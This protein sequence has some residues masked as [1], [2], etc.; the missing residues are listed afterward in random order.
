MSTDCNLV[1]R[2]S[3]WTSRYGWHG[4]IYFPARDLGRTGLCEGNLCMRPID[5][6]L[7]W[8]ETF[9]GSGWDVKVVLWVRLFLQ[10]GWQVCNSSNLA[11]C[12]GKHFCGN[13][14]CSLT[15]VQYFT[16]GLKGPEHLAGGEQVESSCDHN[17][18]YTSWIILN[19]TRCSLNSLWKAL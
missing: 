2:R 9:M 17:C 15:K 16:E 6:Q 11:I 18:S 3:K 5:V 19:P 4:Q 12:S 13:V 10:A 14:L 1:L 7:Q 8:Q